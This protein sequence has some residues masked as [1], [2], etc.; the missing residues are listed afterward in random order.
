VA[1][2]PETSPRVRPLERLRRFFP[3]WRWLIAIVP[4]SLYSASEPGLVP[5]TLVPFVAWVWLLR[6]SWK[7]R[8]IRE[9]A[10]PVLGLGIIWAAVAVAPGFVLSRS[11]MTD[12]AEAILAGESA[13]DQ[14]AQMIGLVPVW[15]IRT[16][17]CGQADFVFFKTGD[18][19]F[20]EAG[21]GYTRGEPLNSETEGHCHV[22]HLDGD[23]YRLRT[24][25]DVS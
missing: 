7:R 3:D 8:E 12:E 21:Y 19:G 11:A 1:G 2:D 20:S 14:G 16:M 6:R 18:I 10:L 4:P 13:E 25:I 24:L 15:Q 17:Q 22:A 5:L 9:I 23:W